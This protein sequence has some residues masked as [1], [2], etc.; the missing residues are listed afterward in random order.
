[1]CLLLLCLI[2]NAHSAEREDPTV[3]NTLHRIVGSVIDKDA[4]TIKQV[5]TEKQD[6]KVINIGLAR[7]ATSSFVAAMAELGIKSYHMKDGVQDTPGHMDLWIA[8]SMIAYKEGS[9]DIKEDWNN[10]PAMTESRE[11]LF[12]AIAEAG[13]NATA[14]MPMNHYF[15]E[16]LTRYPKAKV[17]LTEHW[18]GDA[19]KWEESVLATI[20]QNAKLFRQRPWVWI[21]MVQE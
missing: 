16:L 21:S 18:S 14:D 2:L 4:G 15:R 10:D 1:M 6:M 5:V 19:K 20:G 3:G 9:D 11:A 17:V 12:D 13:F 8:H 7:T